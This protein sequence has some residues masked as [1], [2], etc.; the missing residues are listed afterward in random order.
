MST[1]GISRGGK[2]GW[3]VGLTANLYVPI[4]QKFWEPQ[5]PGAVIFL[6][7][8]NGTNLPLHSSVQVE[9]SCNSNAQ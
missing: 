2:G 3:C 4:V 5:T 6:H 9:K 7:A 8:C 1:G